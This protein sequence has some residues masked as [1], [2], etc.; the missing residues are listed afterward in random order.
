MVACTTW[1]HGLSDCAVGSNPTAPT[2]GYYFSL[3]LSL[4]LLRFLRNF[5]H[6][7][8]QEFPLVRSVRRLRTL[9]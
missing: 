7:D 1:R 2:S 4:V 9:Q 5:S 6:W 3:L 8:F